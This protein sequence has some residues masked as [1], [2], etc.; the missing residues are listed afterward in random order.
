MNLSDELQDQS[1][2]AAKASAGLSRKLL[3]GLH[4]S[5]RGDKRVTFRIPQS[6]QDAW[7]ISGSGAKTE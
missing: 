2:I 1:T 7:G 4:S 3:E 5:E 6:L